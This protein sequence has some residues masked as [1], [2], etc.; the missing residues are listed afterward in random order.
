[1][2]GAPENIDASELEQDIWEQNKAD[3]VDV[4]DMHLWS[5]S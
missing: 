4:H 1:M 5:I 3:I 2:E